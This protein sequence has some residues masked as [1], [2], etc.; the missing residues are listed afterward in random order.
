MKA[1]ENL[2]GEIWKQYRDTRYYVSN[3]GRCKK[4]GK[5]KEYFIKPF[6]KKQK[7]G[8][9]YMIVV[10]CDDNGG[11]TTTKFAKMV[12]EAFNG[13]IPEGYCVCH[14]NKCQSDNHLVNLELLTRQELGI[15]HGSR[16]KHNMLIYDIDNDCYYKNTREAAKHLHISRQTVSDYCN[17]KVKNP[18]CNIR[19]SYDE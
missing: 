19:W 15:V 8:S 9:N 4:I 14:R 11:R 17:K 2:K 10:V 5:V 18:M 13:P 7:K 1:V 12:Y 6:V 3:L 16:H